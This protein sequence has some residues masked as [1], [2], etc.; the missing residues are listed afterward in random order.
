[1]LGRRWKGK[2]AGLE[3][4]L[5]WNWDRLGVGG[6]IV[7]FPGYLPEKEAGCG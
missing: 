6:D 4:K 7:H 2:E 1:M 3:I 5:E